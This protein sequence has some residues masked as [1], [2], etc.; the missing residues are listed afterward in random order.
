MIEM[1]EIRQLSDS[2][3]LERIDVEREALAKLRFNHTVAGL[4]ATTAL[5]NK[6]R[7]V[8]RL[9]TEMNARKTANS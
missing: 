8:A 7:D 4:E 5:K 2:D 6:K 1:T 3:L 9:L